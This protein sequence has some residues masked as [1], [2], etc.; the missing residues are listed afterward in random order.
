MAAKHS[1]LCR[2]DTDHRTAVPAILLKQAY[3]HSEVLRRPY[4]LRVYTATM[5]LVVPDITSSNK[6][7]GSDLQ[8]QLVGKKL[9]EENNST[10]SN[11]HSFGT[12]P[13]RPCARQ[14]RSI[15]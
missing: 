11:Y 9:G 4:C 10:V 7:E 6:S 13:S 15:V 2:H 12:P 5:P 1:I 14:K 8:N 3:T